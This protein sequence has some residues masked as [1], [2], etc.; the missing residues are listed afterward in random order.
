MDFLSS[1]EVTGHVVEMARTNQKHFTAEGTQ[2]P[3]EQN[4][5]GS[6][7]NMM[8][9]ALNGVN[10]LEQNSSQMAEKLITDPENTDVHDVTIA[11]AKAN[12][13]VSITK[14]VVDKALRAYQEIM[15]IR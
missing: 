11:M 13:G 10:N 5:N 2:P 14:A 3:L 12:M 1:S 7:G 4:Q 15:S 8:L 9:E 6:F